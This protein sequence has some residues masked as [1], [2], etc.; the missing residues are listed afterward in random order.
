MSVEF[1][2]L[3]DVEV[4]VDGHAVDIGHTRQRCVL[5]A[6]LVEGNRVVPVDQLVDRVWAD[7]APRTARN[8]VSGYMSRL[9]QALAG[10]EDVRITRQPGGYLFEVDPMTVDLHRFA[11]LIARA[12]RV[13]A[14]TAAEGS[15]AAT[16]IEKAL[17]LWQGEPFATLD[18]PWLNT[19]RQR[20]AA[21]RLAAE[22]DRND[23][24]LDRGRHAA[25]VTD[26]SAAVVAHPLD[27][28]LAGQFLL[29]LYRCGRQA[30]AL[31]HYQQIRG[32]LAD[33]L[34][35]D[36]GLPLQLLHQ[37][38]LTTD[39]ALAVPARSDPRPV[40]RALPFGS[41]A[42]QPRERAGAT[43]AAQA[44]SVK[45]PLPAL[46]G[47]QAELATLR[48]MLADL[49]SGAAVVAVSG[50]PGMGKTRLL[51]ELA[52][53]AERAG[54]VVL[55]GRAAEFEQHVPFGIIVNAL[56]DHVS[57]AGQTILARLGAIEVG[58]LRAILPALPAPDADAAPVKLIEAERY[59]LHRA[60]RALLESVAAHRGL[61]LILDDMHWADDG[62][63]ELLEHLL[64]HPPR[65]PLLLAL[66]HRPRQA[67]GRLRHALARGI[68]D[69][70]AELL[71]LSALSPE[72]AAMLL[73]A[74]LST[75][76]R[77]ELYAAS[78]GNPFYLQAL[79]TAGTDSSDTAR[80][81]DPGGSIPASVQA[82][83]AGELSSLT[84][85]ALL[86]ARAAAVVG[87]VVDAEL[88]ARTAGLDLVEVLPA[89]DELAA[90]DLVRPD[91]VGGSVRFRHPLVRHAAYA[92]A[93]AGWRIAAHGRAAAA[94]R[95]RGAPAVDRAP[96]LERSAGRGD[97]EAVDVL[98]EAAVATMHSAP[99]SAAHWLEAALR[100]LPEDAASALERLD[101]LGMRAR[102]L[103]VTGQLR[104]SR[105]ALHELLKL[106][107]AEFAEPRAQIVAFAA[108]I[109]RLIGRP[110]EARSALVTELAML[111][112]Q[113]GPA[114]LA[115]K[116]GLATG[117]LM[118]TDPDQSDDWPG[119]ALDTARRGADRAQLAGALAMTV[120]ADHITVTIDDRTADRLDEAAALIDALP[121]GDL[122][123]HI[124]AIG[125]LGAAEINHERFHNASRHMTR[126]L[127]LARATGQSHVISYLYGLLGSAY[128]VLGDLQA[129]ADCF[130]DE[131]DA[132]LLTGSDWT[133]SLALQHQC[134]IS[135]YQ[136]NLDQALRLG[137]EAVLA[138]D[139]A[140]IGHAGAARGMLGQAHLHNGDPAA[141]LSLLL[142]GGGP[143]LELAEPAARPYWYEALAAAEAALGHPEQ[144]TTWADRAHAHTAGLPWHTGLAH[145]AS[146][147]PLLRTDPHRAI[148][149]AE[150]AAD[151]LTRAGARIDAG[152]A[153]LL[154]GTAHTTTGDTDQ[155]HK[156]FTH[157]RALFDACGVGLFLHQTIRKEHGMNVR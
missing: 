51:L 44:A 148:P 141:A 132:A 32:R 50:D 8:A 155:A 137:E 71:E 96:H 125:W 122:A 118:R 136:G 62:S 104:Q 114:A 2:L 89:L 107:P 76:R 131:L 117:V 77:Q 119:A 102:A 153:H 19:V 138:A 70:Q 26:L 139:T 123:P 73:P 14:D 11:D 57:T 61:V 88:A 40:S 21:Q 55:W 78:D 52:A 54:R 134:S 124:E 59:R 94:L 66:A 95:S 128:T 60:V 1:R 74:G 84:G 16:L 72:D 101:L 7:Q 140:L 58:M 56:E 126:A 121:D 41:S 38:I 145:L 150:T 106:L 34:G 113:H 6:L 85:V 142:S 5:V 46:V 152:R 25:L 120:M 115:L 49:D 147:H 109:E 20:L 65:G 130:A 4:R 83:L 127:A 63:A 92:G 79:A 143:D 69:G 27:E 48:T 156:H 22:L 47:R 68:Q 151:L 135:I 144:A 93:A 154:A 36:P 82:A 42:E 111:D 112:D 81:T 108:T 45:T 3:G 18:T 157:A 98:R 80:T 12:H 86:V 67:P 87:D 9:R 31:Q 30:D 90:R 35:V 103:G 133:R 64:R 110:A 129:A 17:A 29:A 99:A 116:L 15:D 43:G 149:H 105:D 23:L 97:A 28:R 24:A 75:D 39:P 13:G 91:R 100:L 146:V 37:Q 10:V 33:E 53:T